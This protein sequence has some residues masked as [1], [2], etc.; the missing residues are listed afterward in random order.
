MLNAVLWED[1]FEVIIRFGSQTRL[2]VYAKA[3]SADSYIVY[4]R[5]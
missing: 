3:L 4:D 5:I 1:F 2:T